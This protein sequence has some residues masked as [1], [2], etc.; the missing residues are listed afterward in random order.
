MLARVDSC[1][2]LDAREVSPKFVEQLVQALSFKNPEYEDRKRRG[3]Y[4]GSTPEKLCFL[5]QEGYQ[6]R[7][8]RGAIDIVKSLAKQRGISVTCED[9]RVLPIATL[10]G[11][12]PLAMRSY[13]RDGVDRFARVRQGTVIIPCGGGKTRVGMGAIAALLT[14]TL[15]LVHTHDLAQQWIREIEEQLGIEVGFVGG[16]ECRPSLHGVT[17]AIIQ[18][19]VTM[20]REPLDRFLRCFGF[21]I[22]DEAHHVAASTFHTIV[23]RCPARYRLALTATP[24]REDG[25]TALLDLFFGA[26]LLHVKH[27]E[28][29]A[30]GVL[31]VPEVRCVETAFDFK[32]ESADDYSR[33]C[34]ALVED[35]ARHKL[36]VDAVTTEAYAGNICLVLS[37]RVDHCSAVVASLRERG[38][39]AEAL[40]GKVSKKLRTKYLDHARAGTLS[41]VVATSLADEGLDLPRLSRLFLAFPGRSQGRTIQRLGRLM[42]PHPEK[43]DSILFDLVDR[44]VPVL[45]RQHYERRRLYAEVL[46]VSASK[47]GG[48]Q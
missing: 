23:N 45:R 20:Q 32:Y 6:L 2:H 1:L 5:E 14:P 44:K 29:V 18:S 8:P 7:A 46:G 35:Q 34:D 42:R 21:L 40:T 36:L 48:R 26:P 33:M 9:R 22:L 47:L 39:S 24:Q 4:L 15:V 19:L 25:L 43:K 41:V 31:A 10:G 11:L 17:V 12:R 30:A 16:G 3:L 13:Q 27:E 28:L 37:G 38:V